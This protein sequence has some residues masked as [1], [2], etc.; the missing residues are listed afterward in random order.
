[1]EDLGGVTVTKYKV[2]VPFRGVRET[3]FHVGAPF[4]LTQDDLRDLRAA[5]K[6]GYGQSWRKASEDSLRPDERPLPKAIPESDFSY[7]VVDF[8][9][10]S[11]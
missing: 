8:S 6:L 1:M 5:G 4:E 10:S 9:D 11:D 3:F 7:F 2:K